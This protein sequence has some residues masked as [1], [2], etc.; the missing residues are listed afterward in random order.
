[1]HMECLG[2]HTGDELSKLSSL[3][4]HSPISQ[5]VSHRREVQ[6]GGA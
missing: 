6:F 1:M 2:D 4:R 5:I 3:Q